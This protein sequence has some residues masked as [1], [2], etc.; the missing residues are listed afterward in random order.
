MWWQ[1]DVVVRS[2]DDRN[3][4]REHI[5]NAIRRAIIHHFRR[6]PAALFRRHIFRHGPAAFINNQINDVLFVIR[7]GAENLARQIDRWMNFELL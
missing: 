4:L 2:G 1:H 7:A 5:R 6:P 3:R